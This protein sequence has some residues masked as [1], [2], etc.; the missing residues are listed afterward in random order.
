MSVVRAIEKSDTGYHY[1]PREEVKIT[2][3]S[4]STLAEPITVERTDATK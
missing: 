2:D 1:L 3:C 4:V